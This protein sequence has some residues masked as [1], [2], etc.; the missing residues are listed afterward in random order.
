MSTVIERIER[1]YPGRDTLAASE[2]YRVGLGDWLRYESPEEYLAAA[3]KA[4]ELALDAEERREIEDSAAL[5]MRDGGFAEARRIARKMGAKLR[6]AVGREDLASKVEDC[7]SSGRIEIWEDHTKWS[8]H[9]S[10]GL[11]KLCPFHAKGETAR[12][13]R[14]YLPHLIEAGKRYRLQFM[15]VTIRNP[16]LGELKAGVKKIFDAWDKLRRS[17]CFAPVRGAMANLELTWNDAGQSYNLHLHVLLAVARGEDFSWEHVQARWQELTGDP[18]VNFRLV[19]GR[20]GELAN[21]LAEVCKY[22]SKF[23]A[24]TAGSQT[25]EG[26]A[27]GGLLDMPDPAFAEWFAAFWRLRS[28]RSYGIWYNV[29][30]P[31][32]GEEG[33]EDGEPV[34]TLVWREREDRAGRRRLSVILIQA[35]KSA[36][37]ILTTICKLHNWG[38]F[39]ETGPP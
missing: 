13:L 18:I 7:Y 26:K 30:D 1:F 39:L 35:N 6:S 10:C 28:M 36:S 8:P 23:K 27:G 14:K 34:A 20:G 22:T 11:P 4:V 17:K 37:D 19:R 38:V 16:A 21:A 3:G 29:P 32:E 15:T 33:E 24:T 5:V 12:R 2:A 25:N 31:P 9:R